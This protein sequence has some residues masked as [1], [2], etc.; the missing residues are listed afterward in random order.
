MNLGFY[1]GENKFDNPKKMSFTYEVWH[2][3]AEIIQTKIK[4]QS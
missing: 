2:F 1:E 4:L 3:F